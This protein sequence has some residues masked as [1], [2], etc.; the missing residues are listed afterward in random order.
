MPSAYTMAQLELTATCGWPTSAR[1]AVVETVCL[2]ASQSS[3]RDSAGVAGLGHQMTLVV[4]F[5]KVGFNQF[6]AV[7]R[8]DLMSAIKAP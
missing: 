6:R 7:N 1:L 2:S 8:I 5:V 3:V 4:R